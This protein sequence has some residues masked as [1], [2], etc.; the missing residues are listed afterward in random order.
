MKGIIVQ[1]LNDT[2]PVVKDEEVAGNESFDECSTGR[3]SKIID[4]ILSGLGILTQAKHDVAAE[5]HNVK[6]EI[7]D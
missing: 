2:L 7:T 5:S 3:I 1:F 4:L 6:D